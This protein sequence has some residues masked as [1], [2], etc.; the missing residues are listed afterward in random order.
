MCWKQLQETQQLRTVWK[1][2]GAQHFIFAVSREI[3]KPTQTDSHRRAHT[4]N[5]STIEDTKQ[6]LVRERRYKQEEEDVANYRNGTLTTFTLRRTPSDALE[7]TR[8]QRG[9]CAY[10]GVGVVFGVCCGVVLVFMGKSEDKKRTNLD[11][12]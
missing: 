6:R 1:V 4:H 7:E 5:S 11:A 12:S 9:A 8:P 10:G 2:T 3:W